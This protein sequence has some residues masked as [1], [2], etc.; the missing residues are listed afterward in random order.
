MRFLLVFFLFSGTTDRVVNES[1][2]KMSRMLKH[3]EEHIHNKFNRY[4]F[5]FFFCEFANLLFAILGIRMTI[6][7]LNDQF[8]TYGLYVYR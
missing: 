6:K 1:D 5:G 8:I 4:A 2:E 7:F 3:F